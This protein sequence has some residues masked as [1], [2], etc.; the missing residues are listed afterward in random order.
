MKSLDEIQHI[1][2]EINE[3][4]LSYSGNYEHEIDIIDVFENHKFNSDF[5]TE[6]SMF[7]NFQNLTSF[8][9]DYEA[10]HSYLIGYNEAIDYL[11]DE[12]PSL[13]KSIWYAVDYGYDITRVDSE[14]LANILIGEKRLQLWYSF[15]PQIESILEKYNQ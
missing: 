15:Q 6:E 10:F 3:L 2:D 5:F 7:D 14:L 4:Y 11:A 12:D 13:N 8:L 9:D 1:L